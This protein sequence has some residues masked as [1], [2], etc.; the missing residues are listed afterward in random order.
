MTHYVRLLTI[1]CMG[2]LFMSPVT[3]LAMPGEVETGGSTGALFDASTAG[4]IIGTVQCFDGSI[5]EGATVYI[6]GISV[7]ARTNDTGEFQLLTVP[8][9]THALRVEVTNQERLPITDV[10]NVSVAKQGMSDVGTVQLACPE[11]CDGLD[12]NGNVQIDEGLECGESALSTESSG[13]SA[14]TCGNQG[15]TK[16]G[17]ACIDTSLNPRNCGA[18]GNICSAGQV[19]FSANCVAPLLR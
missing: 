6:P 16:C 11:V 18:C 13:S 8:E 19:C 12:N 4:Q 1:V 5:P 10:S 14:S 15:L 17:N 9:G 7:M 3:T 2:L